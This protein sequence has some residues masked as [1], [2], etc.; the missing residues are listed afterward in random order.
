MN[1]AWTQRPRTRFICVGTVLAVLLTGC[2]ASHGDGSAHA[3]S[4]AHPGTPTLGGG[5][6]SGDQDTLAYVDRALDV[7]DTGLYASGERWEQAR[8]Q[9]QETAKTARSPR[10]LDSVLRYATGVAGGKHSSFTPGPDPAVRGERPTSSTSESPRMNVTLPT[11]TTTDGISTLSL[12]ALPVASDDPKASE[13]AMVLADGIDAAAPAT[14]G[15]VVD[16]QGNLGGNMWP[17]LSG[18]SALLPEGPVMFFRDRAGVD[19]AVTVQQ[20]GAG[21]EGMTFVSVG[22]RTQRDGAPIAVLQDRSTASSGEAVLAAFRGLP[23]AR[24]FGQSSSGY[25]SGNATH[26]LSDG[27]RITLTAAEFVD[28]AGKGLGERPVDPDVSIGRTEGAGTDAASKAAAWLRER[29]CF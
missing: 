11:V 5:S 27:S 18:V 20:D 8:A 1:I 7:L 19:T 22:P 26:V 25:G 9:V 28:R 29:G 10:D 6:S 2:G 4:S 23:N 16:V 3:S 24:S 15:W 12:P 14:Y 17:M 13:Y 21:I